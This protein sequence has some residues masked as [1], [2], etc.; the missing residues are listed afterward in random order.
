M[1]IYSCKV[2]KVY[3]KKTKYINNCVLLGLRTSFMRV[4]GRVDYSA[5]RM[6]DS[7]ILIWKEKKNILMPNR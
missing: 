6:G 2:K 5:G 7:I 3:F 1:Y 4:S